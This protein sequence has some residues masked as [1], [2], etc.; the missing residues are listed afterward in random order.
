MNQDNNYIIEPKE[1]AS[2]CIIC[3]LSESK[4]ILC[5][6]CKYFYC[7]DCAKKMNNRCS[8]CY[9]SEKVIIEDNYFYEYENQIHGIMIY[10]PQEIS[11][12]SGAHFLTLVM[13]ISVGTIIGICWI[14][15]I[16]FFVF[17]GIKFLINVINFLFNITQIYL[18]IF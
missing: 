14:T 11:E 5:D 8:I 7:E 1:L 17:I 16:G 13:S 3:W 2:E 15:L 4:I 12:I 9:R 18:I 6:K 10:E